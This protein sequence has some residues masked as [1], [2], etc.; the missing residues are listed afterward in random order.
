MATCYLWCVSD[1][2]VSHGKH[3]RSFRKQITFPL[4]DS[5]ENICT[6]TSG[7]GRKFG[8][9]QRDVHWVFFKYFRGMSRVSSPA[10]S[11][12]PTEFMESS[13]KWFS[14]PVT[15]SKQI[16]VP[17]ILVMFVSWHNY[18]YIVFSQYIYVHNIV[19]VVVNNTL[20][21]MWLERGIFVSL[22]VTTVYIL[23]LSSL[24]FYKNP[25]TTKIKMPFNNR[26][27]PPVWGG[28]PVPVKKPSSF[29]RVHLAVGS[30][31]LSARNY[32]INCAWDWRTEQ[33]APG[34]TQLLHTHTS[35]AQIQRPWQCLKGRE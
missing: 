8:I 21:V 35:A 30:S 9:S 6:G 4:K 3:E 20:G 14:L 26:N 17:G 11:K 10:T 34:P 22:T 23:A 1:R 27:L 13:G 2:R 15:S 33:T 32:G 16:A 7:N 12:P 25:K 19:P 28:I 24:L 5:S 31:E 18:C 29:N